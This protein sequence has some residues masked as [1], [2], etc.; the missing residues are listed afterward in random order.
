VVF[1]LSNR[2]SCRFLMKLESSWQIFEKYPHI[3]F[4]ENP[5]SGSRLVP[6]WRTDGQ[7]DRQMDMAKIIVAISNVTKAP[8][9]RDN[10]SACKGKRPVVLSSV[11]LARSYDFKN[12][13]KQQGVTGSIVAHCQYLLYCRTCP[14]P[15]LTVLSP[16][17]TTCAIKWKVYKFFTLLTKGHVWFSSRQLT[18]WSL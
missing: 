18:G 12:Q 8:K 6:C 17:V 11:F 4:H 10:P 2:C 1:I 14:P 13:T 16:A 15:A 9:K 7:T 3:K 5:S